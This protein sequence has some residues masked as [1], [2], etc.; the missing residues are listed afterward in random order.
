MKKGKGTIIATAN[1]I[2]ELDAKKVSEAMGE[3]LVKQ[4]RLETGKRV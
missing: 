1:V 4:I 2:V 3:L